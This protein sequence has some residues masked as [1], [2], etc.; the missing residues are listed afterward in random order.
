MGLI[1]FAYKKKLQVDIGGG[2]HAGAGQGDVSSGPR[3]QMGLTAFAYKKKL[4]R[5]FSFNFFVWRV[6]TI[7]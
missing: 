5:Y 7:F 1:A 2:R 6:M 4:Q 3:Q